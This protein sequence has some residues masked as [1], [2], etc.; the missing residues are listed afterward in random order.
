MFQPHLCVYSDGSNGRNL[1]EV[2][3]TNYQTQKLQ[4]AVDNNYT[5]HKGTIKWQQQMFCLLALHH[6]RFAVAAV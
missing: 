6:R 1:I 4:G 3:W 5:E 2:T